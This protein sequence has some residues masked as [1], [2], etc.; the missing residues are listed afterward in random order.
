MQFY[1]FKLNSATVFADGLNFIPAP[2]CD[3][4][5]SGL[6]LGQIQINLFEI[7]LCVFLSFSSPLEA[8]EPM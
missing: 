6:K 7:E 4:A 3:L 1:F 2:Q 5:T 8:S